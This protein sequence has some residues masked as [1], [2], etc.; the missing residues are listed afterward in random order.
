MPELLYF[1]PCETLVVSADGLL[2]LVNVIE[3]IN[4]PASVPED[5]HVPVPIHIAIGLHVSPDEEGREIELRLRLL[6]PD[7]GVLR[8]K[9]APPIRLRGVN[10]KH[11]VDFERFPLSPP[12]AY[13][14]ELWLRD[15]ESDDRS[16]IRFARYAIQVIHTPSNASET[17]SDR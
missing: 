9:Q 10:H 4:V 16:E 14:L 2:S 3:N 11:I 17:V 15:G 7:G 1:V 8:D 6:G 13:T 12:G 5:S